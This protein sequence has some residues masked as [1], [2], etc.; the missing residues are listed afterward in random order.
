MKSTDTTPQRLVR[1]I[2][3]RVGDGSFCGTGKRLSG[4]PTA[5]ASVRFLSCACSISVIERREGHRTF[6]RGQ[7]T[8]E[9]S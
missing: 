7:E 1:W 3:A 9:K 5:V 6:R 8:R 4:L 2:V